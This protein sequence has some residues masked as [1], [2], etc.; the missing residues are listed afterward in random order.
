MED[1]LSEKL[2]SG[3]FHDKNLIT[4]TREGEAEELTF[5]TDYDPALERRKSE[6]R[7][8]KDTEA[9]TETAATSE[10]PAALDALG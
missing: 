9:E 2:L 1:P 10:L 4:V 7:D 3:E 6:P 5:D 8:K